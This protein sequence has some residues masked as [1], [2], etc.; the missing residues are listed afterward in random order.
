[1]HDDFELFK[2]KKYSDLLKDIYH[3]SKRKD[4]QINTLISEL[5]PLMKSMGDATVIVPLIKEYLEISVKNDDH[6]V[7]L[8][9]IV[10]RLMGSMNKGDDDSGFGI[11]E[12]EKRRL[13]EEAEE[14]ILKIQEVQIN[15][16]TDNL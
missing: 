9:A 7:K 8:A 6:L 11:S 15:N 2:G 12:E 14:E 13:L 3:N 10:Q 4:R 5:Q 16:E 1:M